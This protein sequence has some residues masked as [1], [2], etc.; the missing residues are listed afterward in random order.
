MRASALAAMS[1]VDDNREPLV[2]E[3]GNAVDDEGEFLDRGDDDLAHV[4]SQQ[5]LQLLAGIRLFQVGNV[6]SG[7]GASDLAIKIDP[8]HHDQHGGILQ[9]GMH[10]QLLRCKHHQQ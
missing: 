4:L 8:I 9:A 10:A 5:L 2:A 7:E 1:L 6:R 3:I